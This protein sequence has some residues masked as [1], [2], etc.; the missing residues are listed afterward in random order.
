[1][2]I[3]K[4][5]N[6]LTP[7]VTGIRFV[8]GMTLIDCMFKDGWH[9]LKSDN[10]LFGE[11]NTPNYY[12]FY[13][14]NPNSITIDDLLDHI[15]SIINFN[16]EEENKN[17]LCE[18]MCNNLKNLFLHHRL[19]ELNTL[20]FVFDNDIKEPTITEIMEPIK[21]TEIKESIITEIK[22]PIKINEKSNTNIILDDNSIFKPICKCIDSEKCS[23]CLGID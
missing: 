1:M 21:I 8:S 23:V 9:I 17:L 14:E 11:N 22:E 18:L 13:S 20:K 7:Y 3:N 19:S 4:R 6:T 16:I 12:M 2:D 5:L 15:E 10:I